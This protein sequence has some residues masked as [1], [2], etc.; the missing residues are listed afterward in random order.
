MKWNRKLTRTLPAEWMT[1]W[2]YVRPFP[3]PLKFINHSP[4]SELPRKKGQLCVEKNVVVFIDAEHS[5]LQP[6][7]RLLTLALMRRFNAGNDVTIGNTYQC[8]LKESAENVATDLKLAE[9]LNFNHGGKYVRGAYMEFERKR[10]VKLGYEYP[11]L[12]SYEE[13]NINYDR[14]AI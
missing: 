12:E 8:Y 7:V 6:A 1:F 3:L 11:I 4:H 14:F 9:E 13:T 10:S 2:K 5:H